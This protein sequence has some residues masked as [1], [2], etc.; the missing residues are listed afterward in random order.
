MA[1]QAPNDDENSHQDENSEQKKEKN[2]RPVDPW[3]ADSHRDDEEGP[4][5]LDEAFKE[6]QK[7]LGG[8]FGGGK[9]N[10]A[11]ASDDNGGFGIALSLL[12]VLGLAL[13]ALSGII[14]VRPSEKAVVLRF[15][16]YRT[17]LE[18]GPHWIPRVVDSDQKIDVKKIHN[19]DYSDQMLNKDENIVYVSMSVF[20]RVEDPAKY[21]FNVVDPSVSLKQATASALRQ[22]VG[23][24][25][26]DEVMTTGRE[27]VGNKVQD[28]IKVILSRY[29]TGI[30]VTEVNIQEVKAPPQVQEAFDDAIKA[31]EDEQRYIDKAKAYT[32]GV[33]PVAEGNAQRLIEEAKA[34]KGRM[35]LR[36]RGDVARYKALL[37]EYLRAPRVT[38]ERLYIDTLETVLSKTSKIF[39]DTAKGGSNQMIYLPLDQLIKQR[40]ATNETDDVQL[41]DSSENTSDT[42]YS[43]SNVSTVNRYPTR[44]S[45]SSY[46][47]PT[48]S[49]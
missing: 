19:Y 32:A 40:Q 34:Y 9:G 3:R 27:E 38:R 48:R 17:T 45:R 20:Y 6:L 43:A 14:I 29:Q 12:I 35:V 28:L 39:L 18:P 15:G 49:Y 42:Q 24:T 4:P 44:M 10:G 47:R 22:V 41:S 31:R 33:V 21:L 46:Q 1:W 8:I 5:D 7:K 30:Q 13:W 36:A 25:T 37:P 16:E 26:L 2:K 23:H 11:S